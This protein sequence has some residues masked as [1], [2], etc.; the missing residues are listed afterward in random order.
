MASECLNEKIPEMNLIWLIGL[1][2]SN[3]SIRFVYLHSI[4]TTFR[5]NCI[6]NLKEFL[7]KFLVCFVF[8]VYCDSWDNNNINNVRYE[9]FT[10]Y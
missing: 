9:C 3:H 4:H 5:A 8:N 1:L 2:H 6:L 10:N 7:A